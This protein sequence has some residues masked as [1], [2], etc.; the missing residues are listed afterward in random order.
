MIEG[1]YEISKGIYAKPKRSGGAVGMLSSLIKLGVRPSSS[2]VE[3]RLGRP[4]H[5]GQGISL[6]QRLNTLI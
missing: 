5:P 3:G 4:C 2:S 6:S 1:I